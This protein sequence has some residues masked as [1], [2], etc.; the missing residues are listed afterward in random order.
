MV[1]PGVLAHTCNHNTVE[2][3]AGGLQIWDQF[4]LSKT[5]SHKTNTNK[6]ETKQERPSLCV[7]V[8]VCWQRFSSLLNELWPGSS[9]LSSQMGLDFGLFFIAQFLRILISQS[10][11]SPSCSVSV[12]PAIWLDSSPTAIVQVVSDGPGLP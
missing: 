10:I 7:C 11:Q 12:L 3:E 5:L 1:E 4:G 8:C 6:P 2:F 9:D